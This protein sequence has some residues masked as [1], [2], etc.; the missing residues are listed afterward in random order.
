MDLKQTL[1]AISDDARGWLSTWARDFS[2]AEARQS[3][4]GEGRPNPLLWQL[5][6]IASVE[7]E[8]AWLF[9]ASSRLVPAD[10]RAV[11]A[12]GSPAP[13][14][15]TRYPQLADLWSLLDVTHA[16]LLRLLERATAE[17]L[18]RPPRETNPYFRSLGQAIYEAA[19]HENYHVGEIGALRKAI[20][21]PKIG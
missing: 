10:L 17:E 20:G 18:D 2:E 9:G 3:G 21:K 5:A 8:V 19:L 6:H 14:P 4:P 1:R 11:C 13:T 15:A 12:S 16:Q 7:D